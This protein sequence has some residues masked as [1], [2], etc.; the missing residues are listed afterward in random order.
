MPS[1]SF[2]NS[3]CHALSLGQ[4]FNSILSNSINSLAPM[5][6]SSSSRVYSPT[7]PLNNDDPA[8]AASTV[9]TNLHP[10]TPNTS[11]TKQRSTSLRP[12]L[13]AIKPRKSSR[14]RKVV[15]LSCMPSLSPD[16]HMIP[17]PEHDNPPPRISS[18]R[19][20]ELRRKSLSE[21]H[22]FRPVSEDEESSMGAK[23]M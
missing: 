12:P 4:L 13:N 7:V 9:R 22:F 20:V 11:P 15:R 21:R 17:P 23:K 14:N 6:N 2:F 16:P 19:N 1:N 10:S 18:S 3:E 5:C 8:S